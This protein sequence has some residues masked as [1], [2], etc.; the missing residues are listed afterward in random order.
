L[1]ATK[2]LQQERRTGINVSAKTKAEIEA[3][4]KYLFEK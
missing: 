4:N 2:F 3:K 1:E